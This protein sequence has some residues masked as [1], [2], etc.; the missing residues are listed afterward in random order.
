MPALSASSC[1]LQSRSPQAALHWADV[2]FVATTPEGMIAIHPQSQFIAT[3]GVFGGFPN[4]APISAAD[5]GTLGLPG[6]YDDGGHLEALMRSSIFVA[7]TVAFI[8]TAGMRPGAVFLPST[9]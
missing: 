6:Y 9:C 2:R 4:R 8:Q 5:Y 3:D 7:L 1:W